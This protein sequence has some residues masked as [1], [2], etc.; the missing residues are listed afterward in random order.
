M[1]YDPDAGWEV[2]DVL[3]RM[4]HDV[5][6]AEFETRVWATV[7]NEEFIQLKV[8]PW[9]RYL[10]DNLPFPFKARYIR[11]EATSPLKNGAEIE[12]I[13]MASEDDCLHEML[14][15]VRWSEQTLAIP[16]WQ[17]RPS[18]PDDKTQAAIFFVASLGRH[19]R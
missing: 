4:V 6:D 12:V 3:K 1:P 17:I 7:C 11:K 15:E 19:W 10:A 9:Y 8:P 16:L 2:A 5:S 14:V 18:E 13:K